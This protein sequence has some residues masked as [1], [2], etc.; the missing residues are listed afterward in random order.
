VLICRSRGG[1]WGLPI[2]FPKGYE[3]LRE[4]A[5]RILASIPDAVMESSGRHLSV[6]KV[7]Q[8]EEDEDNEEED[9]EEEEEEEEKDSNSKKGK[10]KKDASESAEDDEEDDEEDGDDDEE[11]EDEVP[12]D[13]GTTVE[14]VVHVA[15]VTAPKSPAKKTGKGTDE[16]EWL[17]LA[18]EQAARKASATEDSLMHLVDLCARA[19][20][21]LGNK[22]ADM[23]GH[24][25]HDHGPGAAMT[26]LPAQLLEV[27]RKNVGI[28]PLPVTLLSGF[29]GAGKTTLL[30]NI[31]NNRSGLRV[32]LIVNDMASVNVDAQLIKESG[33]HLDQTKEKMVEMQNGCICC[34][35]REDLLVQVSELAT[36][37]KYDYLIIESTGISE[38]LPVA[39]TFSFKD[40]K[41]RSLSSLARLDTCVTVIDSSDFWAKWEDHRKLTDT[42]EGGAGEEDARTII[43]LLVDQIEF[44]DV[45]ILNKMDRIDP[46]VVKSIRG[47]VTKLNPNARVFETT[48]CNLPMTEVLNTGLFDLEKAQ[49]TPE[50]AR[51]LATVHNPETIEYGVTSFIFRSQRPFHPK[52]LHGVLLDL[53][54]RKDPVLK[55]VVRSK[56]HAWL[57]SRPNLAATWAHTGSQVEL[58][59]GNPF[60]A[61]VERAE[62]PQDEAGIAELFSVGWDKRFGDRHSEVVV[63]GVNM[64]ADAVRAKLEAALVDEKDLE[65]EKPQDKWDELDDPFPVWASS[66]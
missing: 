45:V 44:A 8:F 1:E 29:L 37:N 25:G 38:P 42:E 31:L 7:S 58:T 40:K 15:K 63:I 10:G 11:E 28:K 30:N 54:L 52:R 13:L 36:A 16:V 51:E 24:E 20:N 56:G 53:A 57:A 64:N 43:D 39:Q 22:A 66:D 26:K 49:K 12:D 48:R 9:E 62:W 47:V 2:G 55:T 41:G 61:A 4:T 60:W 50:W 33:A 18:P 3:T 34:T 35:L 23:P 59:P 19:E 5:Q 27:L 21:A 6:L 46:A 17:W 65:A 32:A 14:L